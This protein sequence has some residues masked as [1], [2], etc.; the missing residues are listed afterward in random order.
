MSRLISYVIVL[1]ILIPTLSCSHNPHQIEQE[2][3]D[4]I[5]QQ[6]VQF[7][8]PPLANLRELDELAHFHSRNMLEH[9]FF[10]HDDHEGREVADRMDELFPSILYSSIG[11]NIAKQTGSHDPNVA[12]TFVQ[13]WMNSPGHRANILSEDYTYAGVGIAFDDNRIFATQNFAKPM[14][15][16]LS[17]IPQKVPRDKQLTLRLNYLYDIRRGSFQ[18]YLIYPNPEQEY[19]L[20]EQTFVRGFEPLQIEWIDR[21]SFRVTLAFNAGDGV[22]RLSF[23]D[24]ASFSQNGYLISVRSP[25]QQVR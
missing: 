11:E 24:S 15:K 5:N 20:D 6:R 8:L 18:A 19:F 16:L 22:Y 13:G 10:A 21:Q 1:I 17:P 14:V 9:D 12:Q 3:H 2:I 23:G 25:E 7:N 4:L